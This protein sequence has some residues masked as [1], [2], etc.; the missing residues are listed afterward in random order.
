MFFIF[1]FF[2]NTKVQLQE[3]DFQLSF[4]SETIKSYS[5]IEPEEIDQLSHGIGEFDCWSLKMRT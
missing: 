1:I 3:Q 5:T 4:F 2:V